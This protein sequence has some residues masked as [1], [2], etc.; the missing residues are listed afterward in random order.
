MKN[1]YLCC[2]FKYLAHRLLKRVKNLTFRL[3]E[4]AKG[5]GERKNSDKVLLQ[6]EKVRKEVARRRYPF[7]RSQAGA[8]IWLVI[9]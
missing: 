5:T 4:V 9:L 8:R 6:E 3:R 2:F 1:Q 7:C